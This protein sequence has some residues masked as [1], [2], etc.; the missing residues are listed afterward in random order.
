MCV[1][2]VTGYHPPAS[3]FPRDIY[4]IHVPTRLRVRLRVRVSRVFAL[5]LFGRLIKIFGT[6]K[7]EGLI[8]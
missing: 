3:F 2:V 6:N 4:I 8:G 1:I 5:I 7:P